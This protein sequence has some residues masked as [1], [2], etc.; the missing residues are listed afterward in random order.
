MSN[1][2]GVWQSVAAA[3]HATVGAYHPVCHAAVHNPLLS[4]QCKAGYL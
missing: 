3:C 1:A 4:C 2:T